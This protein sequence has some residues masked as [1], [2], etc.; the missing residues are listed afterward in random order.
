MFRHRC[1]NNCV[2]SPHF[3]KTKVGHPHT[4]N[5]TKKNTKGKKRGTKHYKRGEFEHAQANEMNIIKSLDIFLGF[6]LLNHYS[7][8]MTG[9]IG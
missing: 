6:S 1:A 7:G 3:N 4:T 9:M 2:F 5:H 8:L